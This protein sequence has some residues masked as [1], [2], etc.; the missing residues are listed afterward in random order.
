VQGKSNLHSGECYIGE[1]LSELQN[2]YDN[3]EGII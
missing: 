1:Y 2:S 3:T